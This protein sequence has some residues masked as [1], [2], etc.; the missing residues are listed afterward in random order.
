MDIYDLDS[1]HPKYE[2]SRPFVG[3]AGLVIATIFLGSEDQFAKRYVD[4]EWEETPDGI[5]VT[6][7]KPDFNDYIAKPDDMETDIMFAI[8]EELG[9]K[10]QHVNWIN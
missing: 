8:E 4:Y 1:R 2:R 3:D 5:E 10:V 9:R 6:I 7:R